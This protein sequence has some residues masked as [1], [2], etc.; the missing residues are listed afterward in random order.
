[1]SRMTMN[2]VA[3]EAGVGRSTVSHVINNTDT[4]IR[5]SKATRKRVLIAVDKL[6]YRVHIGA[7]F[8]AG[9]R[10]GCIG[11]L[12][13]EDS[14]GVPVSS[15]RISGINRVAVENDCFMVS[16][17]ISR[18]DLQSESYV[19]KLICEHLV[20]GLVVLQSD[21]VPEYL[22]KKI[23][24][25]GIPAVWMQYKQ[26]VNAVWLD[27]TS[28]GLEATRHLIELGHRRI[29]FLDFSAGSGFWNEDRLSGYQVAM[30]E[31]SLAV[32]TL[33]INIP[34]AERPEVIESI[35]SRPHRP[36]AV[37]THSPSSAF[38]LM[39]IAERLG[40]HIPED[41]S[42][43]TVS[44]PGEATL[45][46]PRLT[47]WDNRDPEH[48]YEAA[49]ML[50]ERIRRPEQDVPSRSLKLEMMM[51]ESTGACRET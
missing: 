24:R 42:V 46:T 38:P 32:D 34:R 19:P 45:V 40:I 44:N 11:V 43:V 10:L 15:L 28:Y 18:E 2:D 23:E 50:M 49:Q 21:L 16:V 20:D 37:L 8:T 25:Y 5:I 9:E 12:G 27:E 48:G 13:A 33:C 26:P 7:R 1:M 35:L 31:A 6:G 41:F 3:K 39:L 29:L 14:R 22:H 36:T 47:F 51:G 30:N 4:K 17:E